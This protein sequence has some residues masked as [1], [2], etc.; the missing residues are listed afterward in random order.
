VFFQLKSIQK[1]KLL[2]KSPEENF[3]FF[4]KDFWIFKTFSKNQQENISWPRSLQVFCK[5]LFSFRVRNRPDLAEV[6]GILDLFYFWLFYL[7][8]F[9]IFLLGEKKKN[10]KFLS[11][12]FRKYLNW[13]G[14]SNEVNSVQRRSDQTSAH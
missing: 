11:E 7:G 4:L 6:S 5:I 3:D 13:L 9:C 1:K 10:K 12:N 2:S 8:I 14:F